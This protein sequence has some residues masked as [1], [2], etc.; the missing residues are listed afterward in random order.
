MN[1]DVKEYGPQHAS[2]KHE[3]DIYDVRYSSEGF[4]ILIDTVDK[5]NRRNDLR[6]H[7]EYTDGFRYLD[8]GDLMRY[9]ESGKFNSLYHIYEVLSGGWSNGEALEPGV[10]S[11]RSGSY[12][13]EWFI[14]ST[15]G[16]IA[17]LSDSEPTWEY[18]SV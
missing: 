15:N 9:W 13:K 11:I 1:I 18:V 7:F 12:T 14:S 8:E 3:S 16:C 10:L 5:N 4:D 6:V 2:E 17:V